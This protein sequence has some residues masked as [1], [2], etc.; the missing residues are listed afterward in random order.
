MQVI[1]NFKKGIVSLLLVM[2]SYADETWNFNTTV[3]GNKR[4]MFIVDAE[5]FKSIETKVDADKNTDI[6]FRL[7]GRTSSSDSSWG[8]LDTKYYWNT[9]AL[10]S[11]KKTGGDNSQVN[12]K[13]YT[14]GYIKVKNRSSQNNFT[15][16]RF[17]G[18]EREGSVNKERH[19]SY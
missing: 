2:S 5:F 19:T 11:F 4:A 14:T 12:Q 10:K 1:L 6:E 13:R 3:Q 17:I 8:T 15:R 16:M 18:T 7:K 9:S